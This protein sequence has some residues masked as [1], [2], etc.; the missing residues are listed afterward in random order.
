M[1]NDNANLPEVNL[2]D[3]VH[4]SI[5]VTQGVFECADGKTLESIF[6]LLDVHVRFNE[7]S[8]LYEIKGLKRWETL[9]DLKE[10]YIRN[11]ISERFR[12]TSNSGVRQMYYSGE[13]WSIA[14]GSILSQNTCDPFK[15]W[16][17]SLPEWDYVARIGNVLNEAFGCEDTRL[18]RWASEFLFKGVVQRTYEPGSKLDEMP[19]LVGEQ[20]IGKSSLL[21][22]VLPPDETEW[23]TDG[24]HLAA[25]AKSRAEALQGRVIVEAAEMAGS[26][27][28]ELESLKSFLTR[29]D[30]G[31]VRLAYRRNPEQMLRRCIIVGTSNNSEMLPND[32]SG[33][34]RFV[35]VQCPNGSNVESLCDANRSQ[36]WAEAVYK[37]SN[38][39]P[40]DAPNLPR[41]LMR[42][43]DQINEKHRSSD[44]II[45]DKILAH[46]W[47]DG[48]YSLQ[49]IMETLGIPSNNMGD[50]KR[51]A[52]AL[53][54]TG[55]EQ[56]FETINGKRARRWKHIIV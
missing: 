50:T 10:N 29:Q 46:D 3:Y 18:N 13:R 32:P 40:D 25:D 6:D 19:V 41:D 36:W 34:R 43:R 52:N 7:R 2:T 1:T 37:Y 54:L 30:D 28:A 31:V 35:V 56:V 12:L 16:L 47:H 42:Q 23:F 9:T 14:L 22:N 21:R 48:L 49:E 38:K 55:F 39:E 45:E 53:R 51:V 4:P 26:S 5:R 15:L 24:F 8:K 44:V 17:K 33:N 27:R 20:G 11:E